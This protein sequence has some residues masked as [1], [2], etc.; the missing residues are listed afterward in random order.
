MEGKLSVERGN[1]V[2]LRQGDAKAF[3][4]DLLHVLGHAAEDSLRALQNGHQRAGLILV[5]C[6]KLFKLRKLRSFVIHV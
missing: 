6:D 3:G 2:D 4:D 5:I 1:A